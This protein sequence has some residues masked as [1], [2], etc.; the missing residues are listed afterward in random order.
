MKELK[1]KWYNRWYVYAE[2]IKILKESA[3]DPKI[4]GNYSAGK[5][6]MMLLERGEITKEELKK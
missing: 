2:A 4:A 3:K 5:V 6:L 1:L